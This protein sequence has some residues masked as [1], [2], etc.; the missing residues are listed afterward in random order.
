VN[1]KPDNNLDKYHYCSTARK[2]DNMCGKEGKFYE[3]KE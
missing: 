3:E 2:F 1:G